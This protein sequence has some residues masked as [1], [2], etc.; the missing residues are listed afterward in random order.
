LQNGAAANDA[1]GVDPNHANDSRVQ[2]TKSL[3]SNQTSADESTNSYLIILL[4]L[5]K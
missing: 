5:S 1:N 4:Q 2:S 3:A